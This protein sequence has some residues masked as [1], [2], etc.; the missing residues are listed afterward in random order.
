M[1][2]L[3]TSQYAIRIMSYIANNS[4]DPLCNAKELSETLNIP[5]KFL[6]KIMSDLVKAEIILSIRGREGGYKLSKPASSITIMDILDIFNEYSHHGQCVLGIG[7]CDG[8]NKCSLH[9]QWVK[10]QK[11]IQKMFEETTLDTLDG[12][13]FKL[14]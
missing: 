3:N 12:K 2:L 5:Y 7:K 10:P 4:E 8:T 11:L 13:D 14:C 9:N 6:T 1:Q